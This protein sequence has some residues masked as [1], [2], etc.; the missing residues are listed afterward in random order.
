MLLRLFFF[1]VSDRPSSPHPTPT[2]RNATH[3]GDGADAAGL[4][5]G[6]A[7]RRAHLRVV[8]QELGH[9]LCVWF[10]CV[11][12]M[13]S[14]MWLLQMT[15]QMIGIMVSQ[16]ASVDL[17]P[18]PPPP[19]P[20]PHPPKHT[21]KPTPPLPPPACLP[22]Y[23]DLPHPP[24]PPKKTQTTHTTH[25]TSLP[26]PPPAHFPH[27]RRLAAARLARD[28]HH[29]LLRHQPRHRLAVLPRRQA[30]PPREHRW[31]LGAA[32]AAGLCM[33]W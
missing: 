17:S 11:C 28:N 6:H 16:G 14:F 26:P 12:W 21:P 22:A 31:V 8:K 10:V 5:D 23:V 25:N 13:V 9:L 27:L 32:V 19:P 18:A 30:L 1:P 24:P 15:G 3:H 20:P 7:H 4:R 33:W 2:P 29:V